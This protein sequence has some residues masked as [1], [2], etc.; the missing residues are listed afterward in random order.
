MAF[1]EPRVSIVWAIPFQ[2]VSSSVRFHF[3]VFPVQ[4][5]SISGCFQFR[6]FSFQGRWT[7]RAFRKACPSPGGLREGDPWRRCLATSPFSQT[8]SIGCLA[9]GL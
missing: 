8:A 7:P 3:R 6:E 1:G 4:R 9:A 5:V 2:G